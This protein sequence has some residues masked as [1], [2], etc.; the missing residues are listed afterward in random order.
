MIKR[1]LRDNFI[2]YCVLILSFYALPFL[3]RD[4]GS[5]MFVLMIAMPIICLITAFVYGIKNGFRWRY[6]IATGVIFAPSVF[7]FYNSS[8][9]G[10]IIAFAVSSLLGNLLALPFRKKR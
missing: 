2:F 9:W 5:A 10:Y 7:I 8:A 4:T 3:I 6:A 1:E